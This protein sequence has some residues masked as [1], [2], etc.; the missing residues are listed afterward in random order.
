MI[1]L[2]ALIGA[3][4]LER[5]GPAALFAFAAASAVLSF[6]LFQALRT[7]GMAR[8]QAAAPAAPA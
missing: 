7:L 6:V 4:V 5:W 1:L 3:V 8:L 2:T